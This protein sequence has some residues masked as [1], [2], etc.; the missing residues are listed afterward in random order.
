MGRNGKHSRRRSNKCKGPEVEKE[1]GGTRN[2]RME[3]REA[4]VEARHFF[5]GIARSLCFI[6]IV[7]EGKW[8]ILKRRII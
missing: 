8:K 1:G 3:I 6:L 5:T 2:W 4:V 7:I